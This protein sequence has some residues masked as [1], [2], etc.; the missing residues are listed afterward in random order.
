MW[1]RCSQSKECS[2]TRNGRYL[3][4]LALM[5]SWG[6]KSLNQIGVFQK[7]TWNG[8]EWIIQRNAMIL[9]GLK[10]W[11]PNC[12]NEVLLLAADKILFGKG[13]QSRELRYSVTF[14]FYQFPK[15]REDEKYMDNRHWWMVCPVSTWSGRQHRAKWAWMWLVH[16]D[17]DVCTL[18]HWL[19]CLKQKQNVTIS[20]IQLQMEDEE[21]AWGSEADILSLYSL[22]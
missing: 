6:S 19:C 8:N 21:E 22:K 3:A 9:Y 10:I 11:F 1:Y 5:G 13:K 17:H 2:V 4:L 14:G 15:S 16:T 7:S 12:T 18:K 20:G